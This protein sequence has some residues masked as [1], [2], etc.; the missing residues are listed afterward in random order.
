M[1]MLQRKGDMSRAIAVTVDY[2]FAMNLNNEDAWTGCA[3][4]EQEHRRLLWWTIY[5]LDRRI[6]LLLK[7]P[8][9]IR[10][11]DF[12]VAG[13]TDQSRRT[14]LSRTSLH[15][16]TGSSDEQRPWKPPLPPTQDWYDYLEF[17]IRWSKI[18]TR[19]WDAFFS[20]R[21]SRSIE[22]EQV[23]LIDALLVKL[24][25]GLPPRLRWDVKNL[26]GLLRQGT[27]DKHFRLQIVVFEV[28][29][30]L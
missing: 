27:E 20:L 16:T 2:A 12:I 21:G 15:L 18:A 13:F 8:L 29:N 1:N 11:A 23:E 14:F 25:T 3:L 19:I 10:D 24:Q 26:P 5:F 17:N 30:P 9:L 4:R 28:S 7:R 6:A 22:V